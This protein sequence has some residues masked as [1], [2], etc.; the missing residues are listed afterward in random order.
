MALGTKYLQ[1][2]IKHFQSMVEIEKELLS[3][4]TLRGLEEHIERSQMVIEYYQNKIH[5]LIERG[6]EDG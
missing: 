3:E 5:N 2:D 4:F 6:D 1:E